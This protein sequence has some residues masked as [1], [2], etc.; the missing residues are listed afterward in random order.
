MVMTA[1]RMSVSRVPKVR[2]VRIAVT[3][4]GSAGSATG[5]ATSPIITGQILG[6][7]VNWHADAPAGTSDITVEGATSGLDLYA[8]AN[9]VTDAYKVPSA[10][11]LDAAAAAL[12]GDVTP[13]RV[14]INEGVK[15]TVAQSDALTNCAIVTVFYRPVL[16]EQVEVT[17]TG[18]AG[19]ASGNADS[20]HITGEILGLAINYHASTPA[21]A[22]IT[23]KT[24]TGSVNLYAK[25]DTTTDA[26]AVPVIFG[27]SAANAALSLDVTP[28]HYCVADKINVALAQGDA[29]TAA[30]TVTIFYAPLQA[31]RIPVTT[32]GSAGSASGS[33][34]VTVEGEIV[35]LSVECHADLPGTADIT[36][37]S[38]NGGHNIWARSN[39]ATSVFVAPRL[40][41]VSVADAAL[42]GNVT[43]ECYAEHGGV[44]VAVAQGDALTNAVIVDVFVRG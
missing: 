32:T 39:S 3:T 28:Q 16:A 26:F 23:I 36:V 40:Y 29:L 6:V 13:Q 34:T 42:T 24:K 11:G 22:D 15:V 35:G 27:V 38:A 2:A 14:C 1:T 44:T 18:V 31:V 19:S 9:A 41:G 10:Y 37:S 30:V 21:T 25:D 17:T 7:Q 20:A 4:T 33:A 43:P 12:T 8:K 5:N